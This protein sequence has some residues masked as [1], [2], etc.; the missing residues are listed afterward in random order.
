[1]SIENLVI[2]LASNFARIL[3]LQCFL[4]I[5][6]EKNR[7]KTFLHI[8]SILFCF[9]ITSGGYLLFHKRAVN[10]FTNLLGLFAMAAVFRGNIKKKIVV[11]GL[12]YFLNMICDVVAIIPFSD[13]QLNQS[14]SEI[15]GVGT[16]LLLAAAQ[17]LVKHVIYTRKRVYTMA[18]YWPL[19]ALIPVCSMGLLDFLLRTNLEQKNVIVIEGL[20]L[21]LINLILF[22]LL[23]TTEDAYEKNMEQEV[24]TQTA[25]IYAN[26]L[27][28]IMNTQEQIRSLQHDMKFHVRELTS[29]AEAESSEKMLRYLK[30][31]EEQAGNQKEHVYSGNAQTDGNLN[32]LIH[33]AKKRLNHVQIELKIPEKG[34]LSEFDMNVLLSNLLE[35]AIQAAE[36][37]EEKE[38]VA[39]VSE[40]K[41]VLYIMVK[42]SYDGVC[43]KDGDHFLTLKQ[44][45]QNH[46]YGLKNVKRIVKKY[47]GTMEILEKKP[48]FTVNIML[49][50]EGEMSNYGEKKD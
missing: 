35:N 18:P 10:I 48:W 33:D 26:Q 4:A 27:D 24:E 47:H 1:M 3:I 28:V 30:A 29:M 20:G 39:E 49:Y 14:F 42:N 40:K 16:I 32:Y 2:C 37:T 9:A 19:W 21:L 7:Q 13:Y 41:S 44:N 5:F 43:K 22:Y 23:Q 31:M 25:R 17:F 50:L 45:D 46:G 12:I 6:F 8:L 38:L 11:V 36:K 15:R 34:L